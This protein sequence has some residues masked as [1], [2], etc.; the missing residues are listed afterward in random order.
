MMSELEQSANVAGR[1]KTGEAV[2]RLHGQGLMWGGLF[3]STD[4]GH[5]TVLMTALRRN[6]EERGVV[7]YLV[8]I[9]GFMISPALDVDEVD[10]RAALGI[11]SGCVVDAVA[12]V[13]PGGH[14]G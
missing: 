10:L 2:V 8:P 6:C 9:G 12:E 11:L 4:E 7:P 5:K 1:G 3:T 13:G 14:C